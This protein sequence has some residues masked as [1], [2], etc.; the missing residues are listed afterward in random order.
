MPLFG[1]EHVDRYRATDGEEGHDWQA[2]QTLLLTT[3]GNKSGEL[4]TTPLIYAKQGDVYTVVA[5]KGGAD[6]PPAWYLNLRDNPKE[7]QRREQDV[8]DP[9]VARSRIYKLP[10]AI[11]CDALKIAYATQGRAQY[12]DVF[13]LVRGLRK[14]LNFQI[15][16]GGALGLR[17]VGPSLR[18][19]KSY[20]LQDER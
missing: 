16:L 11:V 19:L 5:S 2:T 7:F 6:T 20:W 4:R 8:R 17:R 13:L 12:R 10:V 18:V 3:K 9:F 15:R 14:F 1:Q